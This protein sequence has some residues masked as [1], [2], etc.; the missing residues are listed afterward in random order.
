[1]LFLSFGTASWFPLP[2]KKKTQGLP[3]P[4]LF[5]FKFLFTPKVGLVLKAWYAIAIGVS[6]P[7]AR[8]LAP[9]EISNH[10]YLVNLHL[11]SH[12]A[13]TQEISV[14]EIPRGCRK[15]MRPTSIETRPDLNK[16]SMPDSPFHAHH[17]S[18]R[19]T[20]RGNTVVFKV[21]RIPA[22]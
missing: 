11:N 13:L 10:T 22:V 16:I 9:N 3:S 21:E 19:V 6:K 17:V 14:F 5:Q 7:T 8:F 2:A 1:M 15:A 20:E 4:G 12:M 18:E